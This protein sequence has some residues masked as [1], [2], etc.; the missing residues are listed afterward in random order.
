MASVM[1]RANDLDFVWIGQ[2]TNNTI[3]VSS[4]ACC[5]L[6]LG[7]GAVGGVSKFSVFLDFQFSCVVGA[8]RD[9]RSVH[10]RFSLVD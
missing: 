6:L 10:N 2:T 7:V 9:A 5:V 1:E 4:S 3:Q 8:P